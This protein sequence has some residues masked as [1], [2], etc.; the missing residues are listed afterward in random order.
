MLRLFSLETY[1]VLQFIGLKQ[2][3]ATLWLNLA[4]NI[5]ARNPSSM[6]IVYFH[7]TV[8]NTVSTK[9]VAIIN[10]LPLETILGFNHE[11]SAKPENELQ[12][13]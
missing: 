9:K 5:L 8:H 2:I 6:H 13:Y 12:S 4:D 1:T 10:A 3:Q 7:R 11:T